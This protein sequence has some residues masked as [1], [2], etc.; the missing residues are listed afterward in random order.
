MVNLN[1]IHLLIN[2]H[3]IEVQEKA[4]SYL[5]IM[6]LK[7]LPEFGFVLKNV[8]VSKVIISTKSNYGH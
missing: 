5:K 6:I 8:D 3:V 7:T 4:I 2:L 1:V